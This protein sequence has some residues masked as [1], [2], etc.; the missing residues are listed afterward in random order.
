MQNLSVFQLVALGICVALGITGIIVFALFNRSGSTAVG[1]VVIWGTVPQHD[2]DTLLQDLRSG[3]SRF[4]NVSYQERPAATYN[5]DLLNA[6]ASG[7][8]PDLVLLSQDAIVPFEDKLQLI[9]YGTV[10][11]SAYQSSFVSEANLFLVPQGILAMPFTLDPLVMY[12]NTDSFAAAG[13]PNPPKYWD[14]LLQEI[15][16]LTALSAG[17]N[18]QKSAIAMGTWDNVTDAKAVLSA[19]IMQAGDP[20]VAVSSSGK[21]AAVFGGKAP[22]AAEVPASSALR[23]YTDFADPGK[24]SYS[25]NRTL[26]LSQEAFAAGDLAVYIGF[27]SEYQSLAARNP[28]LNFKVAELPQARGETTPLT[29]GQLAGL[30]IPRGAKNYQGATIIAQLLSGD[31]AAGIIAD[32]LGLPPVR[33]D[34]LAPV[35]SN[36]AQTAYRQSALIATGWLDPDTSA[37]DG[38]FKS[39]VESVLSGANDP[40]QAVSVA[41]LALRRLLPQ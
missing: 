35:A 25:W 41:G 40:T 37:T 6:I 4:L 19:L 7:Q 5:T 15:S 12:W 38:L 8:A 18:I 33:R 30:A 29:Y 10:S 9:P 21:P 20:I 28:N 32:E 14:D 34:L 39:M 16:S 27:A 2:M 17:G 22:E 31:K 13:I 11:Q 26:P 3:D 23:F 1:T 24:T 36:A